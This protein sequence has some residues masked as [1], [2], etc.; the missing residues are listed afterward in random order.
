MYAWAWSSSSARERGCAGGADASRS[1]YRR[2]TRSMTCSARS[3]S[4]RE[5]APV[6]EPCGGSAEEPRGQP[7]QPTVAG[8]PDRGET[9]ELRR[10]L[11]QGG[12]RQLQDQQVERLRGAE[13]GR[14]RGVIAGHVAGLQHHGP[15]LLRTVRAGPAAAPR[16]AGTRGRRRRCPPACGSSCW[17]PPRSGRSRRRTAHR[18]TSGPRTG[19]SR[20][21]GSEAGGRRRTTTC[22]QNST[23]WG[24]ATT[25]VSIS[26]VIAQ[27]SVS[28]LPLR[29]RV[30]TLP[31]G[32]ETAVEAVPRR[33]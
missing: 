6:G 2:R 27:A 20:R 12:P 19:R 3:A 23:R 8:D 26:N 30:F 11:A 33:R 31:A 28:H 14:L 9:R 21:C 10:V 25:Q 13:D 16:G 18:P 22:A 29:S 1:T 5:I 32:S 17:T 7:R 15:V 4:S 24:G